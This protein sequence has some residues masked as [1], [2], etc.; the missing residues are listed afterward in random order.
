M[1]AALVTCDV[2][3]VFCSGLPAAAAGASAQI[4]PLTAQ[5]GPAGRRVRSNASH[6]PVLSR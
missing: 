4:P 2:A 5:G 3:L 1:F 6:V